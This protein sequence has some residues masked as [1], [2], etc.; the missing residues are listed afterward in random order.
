LGEGATPLLR[1]AKS[2]DIEMVR[3]LVEH[4]ADPLA[5]MPNGTTALHFVAG[6]GWRDGSPVAPSYDQGTEAE[7]VQ[8]IDYLLELGLPIGVTN[9]G[10]DTP[11]HSAI[12]G[13][14]SSVIVAHL[15][16]RGADPLIENGRGQTPLAMSERE[17]EVIAELTRTAALARTA[18]E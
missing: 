1:A 2:G 14:G 4:G 9:D 16:E 10:G 12:S 6:L 8:T 11:L 15:I 13:R 5:T 18:A 17:S 7:A 3:L